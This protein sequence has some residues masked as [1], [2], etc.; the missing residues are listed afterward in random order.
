MFGDRANERQPGPITFPEAGD[1]TIKMHVI[2]DRGQGHEVTV[3]VH[4]KK[5][6]P[7]PIATIVSPPG[8]VTILEGEQVN[9]IGEVESTGE[10]HYEWSAVKEGE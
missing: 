9:F 3:Q 2:D 4:V 6:I 7:A 8:N 5:S 10:I 1:Y